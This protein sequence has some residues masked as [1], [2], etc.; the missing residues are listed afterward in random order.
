MTYM[1]VQANLHGE[2]W[3]KQPKQQ[4]PIK[5][6]FVT[7]LLE[8]LCFVLV[9][10]IRLRKSAHDSAVADMCHIISLFLYGVMVVFMNCLPGCN[11]YFNNIKTNSKST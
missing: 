4:R 2:V 5:V 3:R 1:F 9:V 6:T 11:C 7:T 10:D 8:F